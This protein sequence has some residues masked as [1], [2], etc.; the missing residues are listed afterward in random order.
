MRQV[1]A[2]NGSVLELV[3]APP[4]SVARLLDLVGW[5]I[6]RRVPA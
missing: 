1:A 3:G 6:R 4:P 2:A 5:S